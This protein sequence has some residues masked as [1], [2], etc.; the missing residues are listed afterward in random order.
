MPSDKNDLSV[1]RLALE[2][3]D[4]DALKRILQQSSGGDTDQDA[5]RAL[6]QIIADDI[7]GIADDAASYARRRARAPTPDDVAAVADRRCDCRCGSRD[8]SSGAR[9][10]P[11]M[12]PQYMEFD[13]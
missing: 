12:Q 5:V 6:R 9:L 7:V 2:A 8:S 11:P 3:L 4:E 1:H 13:T 10:L